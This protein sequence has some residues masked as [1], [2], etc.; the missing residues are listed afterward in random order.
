MRFLLIPVREAL[1]AVQD[2]FARWPE[3]QD[4]VSADEL[5][6]LTGLAARFAVIAEALVAYV[7]ALTG[8]PSTN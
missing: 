2:H 3:E 1:P 5:V 4:P 8:R 7:K 6:E